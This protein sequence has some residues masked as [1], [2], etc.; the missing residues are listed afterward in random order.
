[1]FVGT[2]A[3]LALPQDIPAPSPIRV[4]DLCA[5]PGGKS[6]HLAS[7]LREKYGNNFLL[8]CNEVMR[9]RATVLLENMALWGDPCT[10]VTSVDPSAFGRM[11][12]FFDMIVV[13]APCSGE[14]MFRKDPSAREQWSEDAVNLCARRQRRILSDVLPSLREGGTLIYSTCTFNTLENEEN[15]MFLEEN[16]ALTEVKPSQALAD[17]WTS[18]GILRSER[19]GWRLLPGVVNGEGQ[20]A[21]AL[22]RE[23][24]VQRSVPGKGKPSSKNSPAPRNRAQGVSPSTYLEGEFLPIMKDTVTLALPAEIAPL[25]PSLEGLRPL[26]TGILL[27]EMKGKDFCP[28]CDLALCPSLRRGIFQEVELTRSEALSFLHK[29][30]LVFSGLK[31]GYLLLCYDSLPLGFVKNL[32]NRSNNLLPS[33]RRIRMD[34]DG[35]GQQWNDN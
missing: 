19:R 28:S 1:M 10:I 13:D 30:P 26:H 18:C 11:E 33:S 7:I 2:L 8:V 23:E 6:T 29:D 22:R 5:A 25:V 27:G 24:G 31:T 4:L 3:S 17:K 15:V 14:G 9:N 16:F 20:Y 21:C 35:R 34:I 12:G 32:G